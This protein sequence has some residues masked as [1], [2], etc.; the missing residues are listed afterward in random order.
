MKFG[1]LFRKELMDMLNKQTILTM[2][3]SVVALVG[4]GKVLSQTIDE[5]TKESTSIIICDQDKTEFTQGVLAEIESEIKDAGVDGNMF[6]QVEL[7]SDDYPA[8]LKR[9]DIKNVVII[10]KG[11]TEKVEK[12]EKADVKYIGKMTTLAT[13]S[14]SS[15]SSSASKELVSECVKLKIYAEKKAQGKL[16]DDEILQLE[17]PVN[18]EETTVV[19]SRSEEVSGTV[20][21]ALCSAQSMVVP[22]I[23]FVLIMFSSQMILGAI[24]TEKID[25][26]LETLLSAPISRLSVISAKM[27]AAGCVA[28][29]QAIVYMIGMKQMTSGLT[30]AMGDTSDYNEIMKNLGLTMDVQQYVM[31]GLQMFLS[32]LI[33]LSISLVLGVLAS[34]AKTAQSLIMPI[35][36]ATM[37]PYFLSMMIDINSASPL[38]K[39]I[40]YAIPF[41]HAFTASENAMFGNT[42]VYWGGFA[43]QLVF[44][45]VCMTIA[46]RTFMSDRIFTM[47]LGAKAKNKKGET[48]EE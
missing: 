25:K 10:P 18:F 5:T 12:D 26:T 24:S 28:A 32:I 47:T 45:I 34:D 33:A 38:V 46:L 2:V 48:T 40:A 31:V 7:E 37:V 30:S 1:K 3:I 13:I 22:I 14:G 17:D 21:Q 35:N 41:T 29:M 27:L 23:M 39:Y 43:Y 9:L 36:F 11:F 15:S 8:E 4:A 16:T 44:L 20:L 6:K 19:G 42:S